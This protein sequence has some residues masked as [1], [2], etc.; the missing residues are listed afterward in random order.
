MKEPMSRE[1]FLQRAA[2]L[3]DQLVGPQEGE[4]FD[5]IE[6]KAVRGGKEMSR[7]LMEARLR[8][9]AARPGVQTAACPRCGKPMRTQ[10][11]KASGHVTTP[12]SPV[13]YERAYCVCDGCGFSF[14][15][16]RPKTS[17]P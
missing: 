13:K 1:E 12:C 4:T 2:R 9:E 8:R 17:D 5:P 11:S 16:G 15:P 7:L 14:F 3:Y 6:R 10:D